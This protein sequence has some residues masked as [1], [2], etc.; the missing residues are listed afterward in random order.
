MVAALARQEMSAAPRPRGGSISPLEEFAAEVL[1]LIDEQ[2]D[3]TL[4]ETQIQR[5]AS[6]GLKPAAASLWR[7]STDTALPLKKPAAERQRADVAR[8]RRRW[9]REQGMLDP[10]P[11]GVYRRNGGKH[12]HGAAQGAGSSG[13]RVIG[14]V[15]LGTWKTITSW[16]PCA[17][18]K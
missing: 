2:P 3:L 11:A 7:F 15:P 18:I 12:Q 16:P 8:A 17:T 4:V 10:R 6:G 9:I 13:I 1:A 5:C 14:A